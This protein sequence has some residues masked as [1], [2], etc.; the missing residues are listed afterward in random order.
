[1]VVV[2]SFAVMIWTS[3][4]ILKD[5]K[6]GLDLQGGFEILYEAE[7]LDETQTLNQGILQEAARSLAQ[8]ANAT[9]VSEPEVFPEGDN[10]IR[11][12]IA[13]V[14]NQE[15]VREILRTPAVLTFRSS[16]GCENPMQYCKI[17]LRGNDFVEGG[18]K[19][20]F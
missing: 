18:A 8:R 14:A 20:Q 17:E 6:L 19:V 5:I 9:G 3:P 2:V 12:R 15:E 11:V 1:L 4:G 13:G 7:P 10:R 16:D